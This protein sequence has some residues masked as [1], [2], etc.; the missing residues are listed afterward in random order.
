MT[1]NLERFQILKL[2]GYRNIDI[3]IKDNN[4]IIVGEN[5]SGKTTFLRILFYFLS[6]RWFSLGQFNFSSI[7]ATIDGEEYPIK[8]EDIDKIYD[9]MSNDF[10]NEIPSAIRNKIRDFI[11]TGDLDQVPRELHITCDR[12]GVPLDKILRRIEFSDEF[13][14]NK[15]RYIKRTIQNVQDAIG[16]QILY[17]PTYRRIEREL[18]SILENRE[19]DRY[20]YR[21]ERHFPQKTKSEYIELVEFGMNDVKNAIKNTL[22][23]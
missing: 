23:D 1:G 20:H 17:L 2:H 3:D 15:N 22:D 14:K 18:S 12:Y 6:G 8:Y 19:F 10:L 5:G 21:N 16:A 11:L 9:E 13:S 4:L 7:I